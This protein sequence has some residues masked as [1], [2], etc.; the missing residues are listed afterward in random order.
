MPNGQ[1][2]PNLGWC[3]TPTLIAM[4]LKEIIIPE[5]ILGVVE[6]ISRY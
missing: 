3:Q 1:A 5:H 6:G 2:V 4:I